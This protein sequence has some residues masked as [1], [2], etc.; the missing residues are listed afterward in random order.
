[1][2]LRKR[3]LA[4]LV[5]AGFIAA[6]TDSSTAPTS[7]V[8]VV[9]FQP[10]VSSSAPLESFALAIDSAHLSVQRPGDATT[11]IDTTAYFDPN[12]ETLELRLQVALQASTEMLDVAMELRAGTT[13]LFAGSQM[14]EV[15]AG[16]PDMSKPPPEFTLTFE[17]PGADVANLTVVP[18][19]TV[20]TFGDSIQLSVTAQD[21]N[22]QP[23][24]Q[25]F[26]AWLVD[27][28]PSNAV[29]GAGLF[30]AP[31]GRSTV[32]VSAITPT[33]VS[34]STAF[35]VVPAPGSM[36]LV[37]GDAQVSLLGDTLPAPLVVRVLGNDGLGV[38][39]RP[40]GAVSV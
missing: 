12:A 33:G 28:A 19:D 13:V 20:V 11:L 30:R 18:Q 24:S 22:S 10:V 5:L 23:V 1:M 7:G 31:S 17:G 38:I 4:P 25:F 14:I 16:D 29:N 2:A 40:P 8:G 6:C 3:L 21:A 9:L 15:K 39:T 34:S 27:G 26:I 37:S 35:T 32:T 36:A